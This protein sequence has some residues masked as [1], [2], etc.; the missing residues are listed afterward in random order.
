MKRQRQLALRLSTP[1]TIETLWDRFPK[2]CRQ[3][4]IQLYVTLIATAA[5]AGPD[6]T[7]TR[8]ETN[9]QADD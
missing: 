2:S 6:S 1:K 3:Q 8:E 4:L 9:E 5:Q 7:T